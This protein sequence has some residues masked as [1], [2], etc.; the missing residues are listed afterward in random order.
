MIQ[1]RSESRCTWFATGID[2][3]SN[4]QSQSAHFVQRST[5]VV[6]D[7]GR[8]IGVLALPTS[9]SSYGCGHGPWLRRSPIS[10]SGA[11]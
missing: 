10:A 1:G 7:Y 4:E 11:A 9:W 8:Q 2:G 6:V 3:I 5:L